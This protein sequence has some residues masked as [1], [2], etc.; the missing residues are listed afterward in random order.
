[1]IIIGLARCIA[2]V[3]V[4]NELAQGDTEYCAGLV[5][6]NS[7]FQMLFFSIYAYIF[8][9]VLPGWLGIASGLKSDYHSSGRRKRVD[10]S[11][12]PFFWRHA[13]PFYYG[14]AQGTAVV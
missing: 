5:A 14:E 2:M 6:F 9:T 1:L 7:I 12:Y 8:V 10:L 11:G 4:W 3:L 13:H